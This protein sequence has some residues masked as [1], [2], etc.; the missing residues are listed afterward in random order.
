M[1]AL[2]LSSPCHGQDCHWPPAEETPSP[3]PETRVGISIAESVTSG[4][5][6]LSVL[7]HDL[8]VKGWV[9]VQLWLFQETLLLFLFFFSLSLAHQ[10]FSLKVI[11]VP[12]PRPSDMCVQVTQSYPTLCNPLD[13][14]P[15][16]SSIH[17]ILQA[18][19]LE[20]VAIFFSRGASWP[21]DWAPISCFG[22]WILNH[23]VT[24]EAP[25]Y[26]DTWLCPTKTRDCRLLCQQ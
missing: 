8:V 10:S 9:Q 1:L 26:Q 17:G 4:D 13:Y 6:V 20:W 21:K 12:L 2:L 3:H 7:L 15:P 19:I 16:G 24:R 5:S 25:V 23:W 11:L 18:R 22:S 14:S